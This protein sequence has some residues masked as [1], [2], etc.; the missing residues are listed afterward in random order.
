MCGF[1]KDLAQGFGEGGASVEFEFFDG[2][3]GEVF[4]E[5]RGGDAGEG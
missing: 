1:V 4:V 3:G 5:V 2:F